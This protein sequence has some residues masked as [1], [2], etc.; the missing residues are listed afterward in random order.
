MKKLIIAEKPSLAKN[1]KSALAKVDKFGVMEFKNKGGKPSASKLLFSGGDKA[2]RKSIFYEG[3]SYIVTYCY[4]HLFDIGILDDYIPEGV[5]GWDLSNL[6][7]FP[8]SFKLRIAEDEGVKKQF[9]LIKY[10]IGRTDVSEIVHCGDADREG[11]LIVRNVLEM[12]GNT[13]PVM[14]LWLPEQTEQ[15]ILSS[16]RNLQPDSNYDHLAAEGKART[17]MDWLFGFNYSRYIILKTNSPKCENFN[18]GRVIIPIVEEIYNREQAIKNFV[19]QTYF[20]VEGAGKKDGIDFKLKDKD[21]FDDKPAADSLCAELNGRETIVKSIESKEVE[22]KSKKLFSLDKLQGKIAKDLK[23]D[24][25]KSMKIIQKLYEDGYITYPRTNTEYL[26]VAEQGRIEEIIEDYKTRGISLVMKKVKAIF[27]D[28]KVESHSAITPT[29]KKPDILSA[30]EQSVYDIIVNRFCAVFALPCKV[31]RTTVTFVNGD[32]EYH[33]SG[34]VIKQ[35]GFMEFEPRKKYEDKGDNDNEDNSAELPSF[36]EG[37]KV[38]ITYISVEKK[39]QAPPRYTTESLN[40]FLKCPYKSLIDDTDNDDEEYRLLLLGC[41]I[42]TVAT[43]T[44]IITKAEKKYKYIS[45][46]NNQFYCTDKGAAFISYLKELQID[47]FKDKNIDFNCYLKDVYKGSMTVEQVIEKTQAEIVDTFNK[48]IAVKEVGN[49]FTAP[50][51]EI[52][53][54]PF[55]GSEIIE[56]KKNYYCAGYKNGCGFKIWHTSYCT[57]S[58]VKDGKTIEYVKEIKVNKTNARGFLSD[59]KQSIIKG[60]Q[61]K[62]GTGDYTV[63]IEYDPQGKN[64]FRSLG[65]ISK[66]YKT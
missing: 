3:N 25:D 17:Y 59:K 16:I 48:D 53:K 10:L 54:C 5:N 9:E 11:E 60:V 37:E 30:D 20:Q 14:R 28:S 13:K 63:A 65:R 56:G 40:D 19:P 50:K 55:C 45:V 51:K 42:G 29:L 8:D 27:D 4:G 24:M 62:N 64:K 46:K 26:A 34:D 31:L 35:K 1:V 23:M 2:G 7:I 41:E 6:P 21:R 43:R 12:A 52:G 39:T 22:L 47:L 66:P 38:E 33:I 36:V 15:T 18:A 44:D 32:R 58:F 61:E 57:F 49:K